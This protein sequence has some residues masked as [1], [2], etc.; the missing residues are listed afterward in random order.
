MKNA[1]KPLSPDIEARW[2]HQAQLFALDALMAES[3]WGASQVA[4]Q[5]G[6][7]LHLSWQSPRFSE[8]LD[9]LIARQVADIDRV[10][11][12]VARRIQERFIA[13][14][15]AFTVE[16]QD[17]TR[18]AARMPVYYLNLEHPSYIGKA[19]VKVE[20]WR[21][22]ADYLAAY[23]TELRTPAAHG[24]WVSRVSHPVPAATLETAFCDK[25]TAFA[26]R[27]YLKWRDVYDLWWIGTQTDVRLDRTAI[28]RQFHHNLS[29]YSPPEGLSP[30]AAL[31][32][33][34][35]RPRDEVV[36]Q[37]DPELKRWLPP[38]VWARVYPEGIGEMVDY[39]RRILDEVASSLEEEAS[40]SAERTLPKRVRP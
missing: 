38:S 1:K 33:F 35:E 31:R 17:K 15:P 14:D 12:R 30:S 21:V 24:E 10:M 8:D 26:T 39:A 28:V 25:L 34:L 6:T 40:A 27:P 2:S 13:E 9:F 11:P 5:G 37:A 22:D 29:A 3:S 36:R 18:D 7:S 16:L 32:R 23:P 4:F 19:R 20:F